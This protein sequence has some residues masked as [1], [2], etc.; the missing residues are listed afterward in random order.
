[1]SVACRT[2]G[3]PGLRTYFTAKPPFSLPGA[4]LPR[5]QFRNTWPSS[6]GRAKGRELGRAEGGNGR[7]GILPAL[8]RERSS[9]GRSMATT[10]AAVSTD[11]TADLDH[12]ARHY[13]FRGGNE[14]ASF[15]RANPEVVAP[16]LDALDVAPRYFGADTPLALEVVRDPEARDNTELFAFIQSAA[17]VDDALAQLRRFE[18][19][20]WA[21]ALYRANLKLMFG[22]E[23]R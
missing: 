21:E 11:S 20:W 4:W 3:P 15:I 8:D 2:P 6:D 23:Y 5:C 12:L 22:L 1:M 7:R 14:V 18:D 16:L 10:L 9:E 13:E 17:S 19:D